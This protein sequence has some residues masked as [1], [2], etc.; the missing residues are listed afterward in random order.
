MVSLASRGRCVHRAAVDCAAVDCA[1]VDRADKLHSHDMTTASAGFA[2]MEVVN[3][4]LVGHPEVKSAITRQKPPLSGPL[5]IVLNE[6]DGFRPRPKR[7]CVETE[8]SESEKKDSG[9]KRVSH[10]V[11]TVHMVAPVRVLDNSVII[12]CIDN[13]SNRMP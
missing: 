10:V 9:E 6:R 12:R 11:D 3:Q 1:A 8:R 5:T 13:D 4:S 2:T 7:L